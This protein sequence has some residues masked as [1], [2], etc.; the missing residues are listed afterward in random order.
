MPI[1]LQPPSALQPPSE[2]WQRA[3]NEYRTKPHFPGNILDMDENSAEYLEE[4]RMAYDVY[5]SSE[6]WDD[7]IHSNLEWFNGI[8]KATPTY[9]GS[10]LDDDHSSSALNNLI[11][12]HREYRVYTYDGQAPRDEVYPRVYPRNDGLLVQ[13]QQRSYLEGAFP[14]SDIDFWHSVIRK[15]DLM[16]YFIVLGTGSFMISD[17]DDFFDK[18]RLRMNLNPDPNPNPEIIQKTGHYFM[19]NIPANDSWRY[20]VTQF[21]ERDRQDVRELRPR[22]IPR[23]EWKDWKSYSRIGLPDL[24]FIYGLADGFTRGFTENL[25]LWSCENVC[26]F[27]FFDRRYNGRSVESQLFDAIESMQRPNN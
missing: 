13:E 16:Y 4:L 14:I 27:S 3:F 18:A 22:A 10:N 6:T 7:L 1:T 23:P 25:A 2:N 24:I 19:T 20:T 17:V 11:R 12:L 5:G 26:Y 9:F 8:I 21:R 15:T